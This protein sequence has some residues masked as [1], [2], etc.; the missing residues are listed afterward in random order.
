MLKHSTNLATAPDK[1]TAEPA[2]GAAPARNRYSVKA[3]AQPSILAKVL[4]VFAIRS[5][6]P[7]RV[8]SRMSE[9]APG[10]L[11][12]EVEVGGLEPVAAQHLRA[13]IEQFP[14]VRSVRLFGL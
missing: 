7:V 14:D 10:E 13:R 3:F 5:L 11:R 6:V 4:E 12:I 9:L 2:P 1:T 8:S